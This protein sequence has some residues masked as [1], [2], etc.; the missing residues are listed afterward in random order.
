MG[1]RRS[2]KDHITLYL[3]DEEDNE[4]SQFMWNIDVQPYK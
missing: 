4:A 1:S 3:I 2:V